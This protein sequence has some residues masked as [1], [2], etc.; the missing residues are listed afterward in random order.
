M[1]PVAIYVHTPFCPSKC[2]YCDFNS[3]A[4]SG[5]IM[6]RTTRAMIQEIKNSPWKGVPAKTIFFG[7]GTP[8]FLP[9]DQLLAIFESVLET[10]PTTHETEITSEANPGTVDSEKFREMVAAGFNRLSLGAQSFVQDDL[11]R[12]ERIHQASDI[13]RAFRLAREAGFENVNLD[14]MFALPHQS[15]HGWSQ[16]LKKAMELRP[17]HISLYCLT[18]EPNTKFFKLRQQGA[19]DLPND[20][21]Q[22][23][24][25]ENCLETCTKNG[26]SQYEISNFCQPG[27]ECQH[28]LEYWRRNPYIGYGPGAVGCMDGRNAGESVPIGRFRS[29]NWKHPEGYCDRIEAGESIIAEFESIDE[30]T[31]R[32]EQIML[33]IRLNAGL[34]MNGL[35][36]PEHKVTELIN[37]NW[38]EMS[39]EVIKLTDEG[40]HFCTEVALELAS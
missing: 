34:P 39:G 28:N 7:G 13:E 2:G 31:A 27:K 29:T 32:L 12:L 36:L 23:E 1:E 33:G 15:I 8:T 22:V 9:I 3:Y 20:E 38:I 4:L 26:F 19:L 24:M 18:I 35:N 10:H 6:A 21:F 14:L 25:Y 30:A 37:R 16:N 17:D 11:V 40:R 5:E